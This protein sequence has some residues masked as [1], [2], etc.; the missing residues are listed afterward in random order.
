[1]KLF[2]LCIN[3]FACL[4]LNRYSTGLFV[5][6]SSVKP[7]CTKVT[8]CRLLLHF[9]SLNRFLWHHFRDR[10]TLG[11]PGPDPN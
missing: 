1:M 10:G 7:N 6:Y 2:D 4:K 9:I 8:Y 11:E 3:T 5:S